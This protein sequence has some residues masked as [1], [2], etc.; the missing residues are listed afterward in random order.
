[1]TTTPPTRPLCVDLDGTLLATDT[2]WE[3]FA[4]AIRRR[5]LS[6]PFACL[7]ALRHGRAALK[8]MLAARGPLR[9]ELLPRR[10]EVVDFLRAEK[11][12]GR[13][14]ILATAADAS[15]ARA[16]ASEVG[17]FDDV[18]AS[19]GATN[20]KGSRKLEAI[21]ARVGDGGFD[22]IG[23]GAADEP[24]WSASTTAYRVGRPRAGDATRFARVFPTPARGTAL[25]RAIRP[26]QWVKNILVFVPLL[27]AHE[28]RD[29][30]RV[31]AG[32]LGFLAVSLCASSVYVVN[33]LADLE[34]D[35][36]HATK[37]R[38][39]FASGAAS[40][41]AG[42]FVA[43]LALSAGLLL[44]WTVS[45]PFLAV[46]A[47]YLVLTTAYTFDI[48]RRL[49]LDVVTLAALYTIRV[50]AGGVATSVDVSPWLLA[51]SMFVFF[52]LALA[53]RYTELSGLDAA[54]APTVSGRG[55]RTDDLQTVSQMGVGSGLLAVLV[56]SLYVSEADT[57]A[58]LYPSR[59]L[60][61]LLCPLML[62][63]ICRLWFI[64]RRG[65]MHDDPIVFALRDPVSYATA[66]LA[67]VVVMASASS[68]VG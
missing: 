51:F 26:H 63:W 3:S 52:S 68:L 18:I 60:L 5:P 19:D 55:Y 24:I 15:I 22:Y 36:L 11:A 59:D 16:V 9:T 14:I 64:T 48:K 21:R 45:A 38:R 27:L 32:L 28:W 66:V 29:A 23:D 49:L 4:A 47:L 58:A 61:W 54:S 34:P 46:L 31:F 44:A 8:R 12:A 2:L 39:P 25:L 43:G 17:V 6:T 41:P 62:Y 42:L 33:D 35:R 10:D 57:A 7:G 30:D 40:I 1:M 65:E 67:V 37:R 53:K 13:T 50:I 20:L 56:L